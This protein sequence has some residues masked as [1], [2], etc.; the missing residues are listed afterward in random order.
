MMV[1][2]AGAIGL[3]LFRMLNPSLPVLG[4][5]VLVCLVSSI[6]L[7]RQHGRLK[8]LREGLI[9]QMDSIIKQRAK[10]EQFYGMATQDALTGLYNRRFGETRLQEEIA[11]AGKSGEPL[12]LIAV[13]FDRFKQINDQYGHAA[14]DL[15]LKE[16]SRRLQ[17]AVR[18]CDVPIRVG[19]D[20][21]LVI[22]PE[23]VL[24]KITEI[25]S[26]MD[27]ITFSFE[28][29][30][31]PVSFSYGAAQYQ[32]HDTPES[33]LKRADE[34]LYA[35]KA[36]RKAAEASSTS[37]SR[38]ANAP[39]AP[40]AAAKPN[41]SPARSLVA[42]AGFRR[43]ERVPFEMPVEVYLSRENEEPVREEAKT[44][45]V[46]AHGAL[47]RL[48]MP[49]EMGQAL[50]LVNPRTQQEVECRVCRFG[51]LHEDDMKEVA[52]EFAAVTP[53]FWDVPSVPADWDPAWV[54]QQEGG[55]RQL[56]PFANAAPPVA[57]KAAISH[58]LDDVEKALRSSSPAEWNPPW[59]PRPVS[60]R[61]QVSI[62]NN[63]APAVRLSAEALSVL[64]DNME[65]VVEGSRPLGNN[66]QRAA[67][68]ES[69]AREV[70]GA[71]R[72][73]A[74]AAST[75]IDTL[76]VVWDDS[77]MV[78]D[79][80][81]LVG[82]DPAWV[83]EPDR[84]LA[85]VPLPEDVPPE[86]PIGPADLLQVKGKKIINEALRN[87]K[88]SS[89]NSTDTA[90]AANARTPKW[91]ILA[92]AFSVVLMIAVGVAMPHKFSGVAA[93]ADTANPARSSTLSEGAAGMTSSPLS[94]STVSGLSQAGLPTGEA[95]LRTS[96]QLPE[97]TVLGAHQCAA[98]EAAP[99]FSTE[100]AQVMPR[101]PGFRL[102]IKADFDPEAVA[103][104]QNEGQQASG[105]ILGDYTGSGEY[106]AY[107]WVGKDKSWQVV[108]PAPAQKRCDVSLPSVAIAARVSKESIN[109]IQWDGP[110]PEPS[111]DGLLIVRSAKDPASGVIFSLRGNDIVGSR[112]ADY[113]QVPLG[114][115]NVAK[116]D[117][118]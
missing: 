28:G 37:A 38:D 74:P 55:C 9:E 73:V 63:A 3:L 41:L 10:T 59:A 42:E 79:V 52:T 34:R 69:E 110:A 33:M 68:R 94:G 75:P 85:K 105:K 21:F 77:E 86:L 89:A 17:R 47:L 66:P 7:R 60:G 65:R 80:S 31:I 112:P 11:R 76:S 20:E 29:N 51:E 8:L 103:W 67:R 49:V 27:S 44:L 83:P 97:S 100:M 117:S 72:D 14:G 53:T 93:S 54:P 23:C 40:E 18:A 22:F 99:G 16:F 113:R 109:R 48:S 19:G 43:S 36:K 30:K 84:G 46:N 98:A 12:V 91:L 92:L 106:P 58:L 26:R 116:T 82:L 13:D 56:S 32:P 24:E 6:T 1:L 111:G 78:K 115:R 4:L 62:S 64:C 88:D 81:R 61:Q 45:S 107:L 118:Q 57:T 90:K 102:A 2:L 71:T 108:I 95:G 87:L 96:S 15:A 39:K 35:K 5:L 50:R 101:V 114:E 70:S 104:L 25:M